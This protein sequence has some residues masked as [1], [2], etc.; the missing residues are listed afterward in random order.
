MA[1]VIAARCQARNSGASRFDL[2]RGSVQD[3]QRGT[4]CPARLTYGPVSIGTSD[5]HEF[6]ETGGVSELECTVN[7]NLDATT[8]IVLQLALPKRL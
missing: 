5:R 7:V 8:E 6:M 4:G 2:D 3:D 1:I